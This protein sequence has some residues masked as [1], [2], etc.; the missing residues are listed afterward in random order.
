MNLRIVI[1]VDES[2]CV[3]DTLESAK[4]AVSTLSQY[5]EV[6]IGVNGVD[7]FYSMGKLRFRNFQR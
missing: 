5:G 6:S 1:A 3:V 7:G 2:I 4:A